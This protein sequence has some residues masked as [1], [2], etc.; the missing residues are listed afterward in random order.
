MAKEKTPLSLALERTEKDA[1]IVERATMAFVQTQI[2]EGK[3][4][5]KRRD[6]FLAANPPS[7][8]PTPSSDPKNSEDS[9]MPL[10]PGHFKPSGSGVYD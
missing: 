6:L 9:S 4:W 5:K 8:E 3:L 1:E 10:L 2:E 7:S